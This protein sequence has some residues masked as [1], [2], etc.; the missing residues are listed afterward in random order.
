[1]G[2]RPDLPFNH[3]R[4][5]VFNRFHHTY[6]RHRPHASHHGRPFM[7]RVNDAPT[8]YTESLFAACFIRYCV[9]LNPM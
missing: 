8:H 1:M 7:T 2:L 5:R 4:T 3:A 6:N 9:E